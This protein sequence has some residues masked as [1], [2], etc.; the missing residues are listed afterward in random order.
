MLASSTSLRP[1]KLQ[2][3]RGIG[4]D[5]TCRSHLGLHKNWLTKLWEVKK[6]DI[7]P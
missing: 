6:R 5:T 4:M 1:S 7:E 3:N 2:D